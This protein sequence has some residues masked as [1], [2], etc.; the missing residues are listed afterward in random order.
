[1]KAFPLL[2]ISVLFLYSC[3]NKGTSSKSNFPVKK[4]LKAVKHLTSEIL[5]PD[6]M[7][8]TGNILSISSSLSD[9]MLYHYSLPEMELIQN[10][11]IKG[12]AEETRLIASL[13]VRRL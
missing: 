3:T 6:F 7:T 9:S 8:I 1:M 2:L 10:T 5:F 4:E 11:G 12:N 13:L